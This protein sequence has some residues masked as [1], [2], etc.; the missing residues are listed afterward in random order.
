[1]SKELLKITHIK[2]GICQ[3]EANFANDY[4]RE[5]AAASVLSLMDKDEKFAKKVID[6]VG[7]Y[8]LRRR[9]VAREN[10]IAIAQGEKKIKN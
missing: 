1:M 10:K 7:M 8:I 3:A 6:Y 9:D 5:L 2:N 4:E